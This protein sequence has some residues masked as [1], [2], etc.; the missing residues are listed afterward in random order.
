VIVKATKMN[1]GER[2]KTIEELKKALSRNGKTTSSKVCPKCQA[3]IT[4]SDKYCRN[5]GSST[6]PIKERPTSSFVFNSRKK[7]TTIQQLVQICYDNWNEAVPHLYSGNFEAW[8]KSIPEGKALAKKAATIRK[9]QSDKNLGLN[10]F[11]SASGFGVPA[12]V[13]IHPTE[14][15][16]GKLP[17]GT[18]K[19]LILTISNKGQ[20]YLKGRIT[21][22]ARW[23]IIN[24]ESFDCFNKSA[25]RLVLKVDTSLLDA[26]KKYKAKIVITSNGGNKTI[27]VSVSVA[28]MLARPDS[29]S[30]HEHKSSIFNSYLSPIVIFAAI[31]L[32][33]RFL[34]PT[35]N[36]SLSKPWIIILMGL[37]VGIMN[38][39]FGK[40][41][42]VLGCLMGASLGAAL[43]II[44]HYTYFFIDEKIVVPFFN[45]LETSYTAK[46]SYTGWGVIGI[47]LGG[48]FAFFKK[49]KRGK[50]A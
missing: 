34:G 7:A 33:I 25:A 24:Q 45:Y 43:N 32:L 36:L 17:R 29:E 39:E 10:E 20:G 47:Y 21:I 37:L 5:C 2:F 4:P 35:A 8:L 6:H 49:R 14:I 18:R 50:N 9:K 16:A 48:T 13:Q 1:K 38:I 30:N 11:L 3:I 46:L 12:Q 15:E 23:I 31:A 44:S 41:G 40:I 22:G 28:S 42:F 19:R 26:F 27:P